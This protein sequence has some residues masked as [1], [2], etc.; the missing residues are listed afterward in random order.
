MFLFIAVNLISLNSQQRINVNDGKGWDGVEYF[1]IAKKF[2]E[3]KEITG[4]APLVYRLGTPFLAS[5]IDKNELLN[6]FFIA[7]ITANFL[8]LLLLF[9]Y[10]KIYLKNFYL[11]I[12]LLIFFLFHWMCNTRFIY[13]YPCITDP[14]GLTFLLMGL[15]LI[16]KYRRKKSVTVIFF[17]CLTSFAGILFREFVFIIPIALLFINNPFD[18]EYLF[19]ISF[20]KF[21]LEDKIKFLPLIAGMIGI[22]LTRQVAENTD[23]SYSFLK[24]VVYFIYNKSLIQ[25]IHAWFFAAGPA[26][27][28]L[29]YFYKNL[30]RFIFENQYMLILLAGA[31]ILSFTG[32]S[33]TGRLILWF[34]PLILLLEGKVI[35]EN[36]SIFKKPFLITCIIV[37]QIFSMKALIT[38]PQPLTNPDI[39]SAP[40]ITQMK[41]IDLS[42]IISSIQNL[43]PLIVSFVK[44]FLT[45]VFLLAM[46]RYYSRN[47]RNAVK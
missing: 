30:F 15:I 37:F 40:T 33:D 27:V 17:L 10:L 21:F 26:I 2:S 6:G 13:Y 29:V 25:Y 4:P 24:T 22:V 28:L 20:R 9:V 3:G 44:Y 36:I 41:D 8:S 39:S 31:I 38:I 35:E 16:E 46:V 5:L 47:E 7:N 43:D 34:I 23:Q 12:A 1:E 18:K 14:W 42:N 32:G 45:A 11:I 19:F